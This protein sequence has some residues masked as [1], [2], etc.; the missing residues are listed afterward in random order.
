MDKLLIIDGSAMLTT[1]YFSLLPDSI[2]NTHDD[3]E[4]KKYYKD[5]LQTSNGVYTNAVYGMLKAIKKIIE[6]QKPKYIC[7]VFD[8]TRE[9][10]RRKLY[11]KYKANRKETQQPLKDQFVLMENILED[12]GFKVF[13]DNEYEADDF[14]GSITRKFEKEI[15]I[16]LMTKDHDYLQL[17]NDNNHVWMMMSSQDKA[18]D[19]YEKYF[20]LINFTPSNAGIPDACFEFGPNQVKGEDGVYPNQIIDLKG[21]VGDVADNI[22][23]VRGVAEKSAIP[24]LNYYGSIDEIYRV[25]DSVK[26]D[27]KKIKELNNFW[28]EE[29]GINRSPINMFLKESVGDTI[30]GREGAY[31]SQKLATIVTNLDIPYKLDDFVC[32]LDYGKLKVICDRLEIKSL[33]V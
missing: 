4:K 13:Y 6:N 20:G 28:K 8:K 21:I 23:G 2:K 32:N 19:L 33:D 22:P 17:V 7:F 27:K 24:L 26:D 1:C 25:I 31:L 5:I 12:L 30:N 16:V 10:F 3:E 18:I 29:L 9:T 14:A 15:P 11:P